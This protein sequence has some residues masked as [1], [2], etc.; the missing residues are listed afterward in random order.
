MAYIDGFVIPI[1]S[2]RVADYRRLARKAGQ[3]WIEYGAL[4][5]HECLA[6]DVKPGKVTSFPQAVKLK[7]D[8]AVVFSWIVYRS[9]R[10]RDAINKKVMADPRI[11]AMDPASMPIDGRRMFWGGFKEI[12]ALIGQPAS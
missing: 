6:D 10:E 8:E 5:V 12:V 7:A 9:K 4:A 2:D 11:A 3:V 1:K